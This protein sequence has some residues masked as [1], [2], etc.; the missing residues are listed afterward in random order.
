VYAYFFRVPAG[1]LAEHDANSLRM[2]TYYLHPAGLG[3]AV[4]GVSLL[5]WRRF[6][7]DPA[8]FLVASVYAFSVFHR[9][10]IVPEHFWM[11]RRF[12]TL[13]MPAALLMASAGVLLGMA[14]ELRRPSQPGRFLATGDRFTR[15]LIRLA[16]LYLLAAG[17]V[18]SVRPLLGHVEY[19]GILPRLE[20][21][22]NRFSPR[23]LVIV[24]SRNASDLHVLALPLAYI[25]A[26]NV[27]VLNTPKPNK[28]AFAGFLED[29]R[30]RY[31]AIYFLGGGGTDLLSKRIG[32]EAVASERFQIPEYESLRNAYPTRSRMKE[33]DYGL[34]RFSTRAAD[35]PWFTLDLGTMDD[36]HVVR[37]HAKERNAAGRSFR[38][39]RELSYVSVLGI[40]PEST[41]LT[42]WMENGGRPQQLPACEVEAFLDDRRLGSV[43]VGPAPRPY[44]FAVPPALAARASKSDEP[45]LLRLLSTT[46]NPRAALGVSDDRN[47]GAMLYR[48]ELR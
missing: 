23:D 15:V 2:F 14:S 26:R 36:L 27:L 8:L 41:A 7:L 42:L 10:R 25:H 38:W 11:A 48:V 32:V 22:A 18:R 5:A 34:Y 16:L 13:I 9:I 30:R 21:L 47:L 31:D 40:T 4:I 3:A 17:S 1:R 6:W 44:T 37:F 19:A 39:T 28:Q 33:F 29:A 35:L 20:A 45:A 12:V 46:W 24:E 43:T